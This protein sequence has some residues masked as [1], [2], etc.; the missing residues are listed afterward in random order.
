MKRILEAELM[1]DTVQARSYA[2]AD[3]EEPH[4]RVIELFRRFFPGK[5]LR[6]NV[7]DIGCGPGDVTFRFAASFPDAQITA[8]DGADEMIRL[9]E[10]RKAKEAV[11]AGITFRVGL[12][13]GAPIPQVEYD[14][15]ISSSFL[16]HLHEPRGLW[17]TIK[18][19]AERGTIIFVIDLLRPDSREKA[20]ELVELYCGSESE[21]LKKDFYNSLLA[22]FR[23]EEVRAQLREAGLPELIV[24]PVSDRHQV[25]YGIRGEGL[26]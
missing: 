9:A 25:I 6:G 21:I 24:G 1:N 20:R 11:G 10:K 8:I 7:L 13:P 16:H 15:I 5:E 26:L 19:H 4:R 14:A 3:F 2:E 17:Q 18:G 23:P 22:A 12:I